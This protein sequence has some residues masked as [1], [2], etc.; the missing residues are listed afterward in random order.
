MELKDC[1]DILA[2]EWGMPGRKA[3]YHAPH[4][5]STIERLLRVHE[6]AKSEDITEPYNDY[7]KTEEQVK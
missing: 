4:L 3:V 1:I 7:K 5:K 2:G 6:V